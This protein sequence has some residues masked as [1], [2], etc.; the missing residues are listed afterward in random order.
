M[1]K[2]LATDKLVLG[3]D[4]YWQSA[5]VIMEGYMSKKNIMGNGRLNIIV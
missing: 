3:I 5:L 1:M 4:G 2:C